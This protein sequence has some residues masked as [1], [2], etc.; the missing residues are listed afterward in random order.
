MKQRFKS[1]RT[2]VSGRDGGTEF[3][4]LSFLLLLLFVATFFGFAAEENRRSTTS[5]PKIETTLSTDPQEV[6]R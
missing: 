2:D 6:S 1:Q 3:D 5:K 4:S